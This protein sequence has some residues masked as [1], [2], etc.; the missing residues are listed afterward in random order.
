MTSGGEPVDA[1]RLIVVPEHAARCGAQDG[2]GVSVS[3]LDLLPAGKSG[4]EPGPASGEAGRRNRRRV[5]VRLFI[6]CRSRQAVAPIMTEDVHGCRSARRF[7][8]TRWTRVCRAKEDSDDGRRALSELCEAYYEPV[9]AYLNAAVQSPERARELAHAFFAGI[10]AGGAVAGASP[11]QGRFR[12][13]LLGAVR[14]FLARRWESEARL[15]RGGG[16]TTVSFDAGMAGAESF[17]EPVD[18]GETPE[19]A[20]DRRWAMTALAL[21]LEALR[22]ECER[23]GKRSLFERVSPWLLGEATHGEQVAAASELRM[24]IS[25][26]KVATHRMRHRMRQCLREVIAGTLRDPALVDEEMRSLMESL[27][28]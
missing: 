7:V 24:G 5:E 12:S 4:R 9:V 14:H 1:E 6:Q 18:G 16:T 15:R 3:R 26:M 11:E 22:R 28:G 8:T 20:Y 25:A 23:E 17:V 13:Y 21:A 19:A 10:L 2:L 27:R